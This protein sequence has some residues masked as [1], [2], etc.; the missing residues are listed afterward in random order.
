[1]PTIFVELKERTY[2]IYLDEGESFPDVMADRFPDRRFALVTNSRLEEL[3]GDLIEEW[4]DKLHAVKHIIPD[5]EQYKQLDTWKGILDTLLARRLDRRAVL[6]AFGGGVVGDIAGFAAATFMRGIDYVQVPTTLLAM[7]DSSVGGKTA[8]NHPMGKNLIG[9]FHQPRLVFIRTGFLTTLP[10]R[11]YFAGYA[12]VFKNAFIGGPEMFAFIDKRHGELMAKDPNALKE[13][14]DRSVRIKARIV[15]EDE[16]ESGNRALL[17]FGHTF[18]HALENNY[19][20][21]GILHGEA[22]HWG[23]ACALDLACRSKL[24]P[25]SAVGRFESIRSKI[26]RPELPSPPQPDDLYRAMFSDKKNLHGA[27]RL[28]LPTEPGISSITEGIDEEAITATLKNVF[29]D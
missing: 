4:C 8:V 26:L 6:V 15:S 19:K 25:P 11:E 27:L 21:T 20:Y 14:I 9:A 16:R 28:V 5:G 17:N 12:E 23:M 13:A 10:D 3:Y 29:T 18:A 2:P 22:V 7:V 1:M 24:V